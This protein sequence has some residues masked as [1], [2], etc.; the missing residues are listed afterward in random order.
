MSL[1]Q[2]IPNVA[3]LEISINSQKSSGSIAPFSKFEWL[4]VTTG[5]NTNA[6]PAFDL[7]FKVL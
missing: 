2:V 7:Y 6:S 1:N 5:T 4:H 3:N